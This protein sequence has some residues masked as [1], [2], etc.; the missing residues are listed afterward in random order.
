MSGSTVQTEG[1]LELSRDS[2]IARIRIQVGTFAE[3]AL[4]IGS[5]SDIGDDAVVH[6]LLIPENVDAR[7]PCNVTGI[8]VFYLGISVETAD[9]ASGASVL[10]SEG[11][12]VG[13]VSMGYDEF[14]IASHWNEG[15]VKL[16]RRPNSVASRLDVPIMWI[17]TEDA[18]F[19]RA[20]SEITNSAALMRE[21]VPLLNFWCAD[22]YRPIPK[23]IEITREL[24]AWAR[25]HNH[26]T[27]AYHTIIPRIKEDPIGRK[28]IL[29]SIMRST[30]DR[31]VRLAN[32]PR[33]RMRQ[34]Q[35]QWQTSF[36]RS[37]GSIHLDNWK[38]ITE[39]MDARIA[40]M[41]YRSPHT[42]D[43]KEAGGSEE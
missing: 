17:S 31:A 29:L 32:F 23:D 39:M 3:E 6:S 21:F 42:F 19:A 8:G 12:V 34:M 33:G 1:S 40:D 16:L 27:K 4:E 22:P 15:K 2:D 43:P 25:D 5:F 35:L 13:V 18:G 24:G 26:K 7:T 9:E 28:A 30:N 37:L 38:R 14:D 10:N 20:A 41:S 36:L 11:K